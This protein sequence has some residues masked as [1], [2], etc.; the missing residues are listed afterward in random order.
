MTTVDAPP[1]AGRREW[2]GLVVLALPTMLTTVDI[3]VLFLA[4]PQLATELGATGTEQLWITDIYAF[5]IAGSLI[6]MGTLGDRIGR[7]KVLLSG[8]AVFIVASLLAA[9]STSPEMLIFSRGLLGIAGATVMPSVM[10]LISNMFKDPAQLGAAYGIW[11]GSIMIGVVLG[12]VVGGILLGAFGWQSVFIMGVPIMALLLLLGPFFLPE[13][14]APEAGRLDLISVVLS[15][16]SILPI[17]YGLKEVARNG[18]QPAAIV[19]LVAGALFTLIFIVRQRRLTSPL[20]DLSLFSIKAVRTGLI[21]ATAIG[22]IMGGVGLTAVLY[23][24]MVEGLSPLQAG[25]WMLA[26]TI[27]MT[28]GGMGIAP[29]IARKVRPAFVLVV[30]MVIAAIGMLVLTQVSSVGGFTTLMIG[31]II[32][33]IGGSPVGGLTQYMLMSSA[34]P[35][36]AGSVSSV[37]STGGELGV[38]LGIAVL[39]SVGTIVF[40]NEVVIPAGVSAGAA[41]T[42]K[43]SVA[44]AVATAQQL[45]GTVGADLLESAREAFTSGLHAVTTVTGVLYIG[46]A[47]LTFV[48]LRHLPPMSGAPG[49][50]PTPGEAAQ[51]EPSKDDTVQTVS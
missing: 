38:A 22:V 33:Y 1:K 16:A 46:L 4:L 18:W 31:L 27:L 23:M 40:R 49:A 24:Q 41:Q 47:I 7:R 34:P 26:P 11:G 43:E 51:T 44:G 25:A 37:S 14:R 30:G 28:V 6:T 20:L 17:V 15:F 8:A 3:S 9:Y 10:A 21:V 13:F 36:K 12:P 48:G 5:L 42:A 19:A 50:P 29:Q 35:E 39:G 2:I 32:A 45:P